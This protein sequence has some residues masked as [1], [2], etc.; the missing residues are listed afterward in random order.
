M[1][2]IK[3]CKLEFTCSKSLLTLHFVNI[4]DKST[5]QEET[6]SLYS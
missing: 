6:I 5:Y 4:A 2:Y 1:I 3:S